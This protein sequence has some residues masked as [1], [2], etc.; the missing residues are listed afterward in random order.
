[1]KDNAFVVVSEEDEFLSRSAFF[2]KLAHACSEGDLRHSRLAPII[3]DVLTSEQRWEPAPLSKINWLITAIRLSD[4]FL[5]QIEAGVESQDWQRDF[6]MVAVPLIVGAART[7]RRSAD[8]QF[9]VARI[10]DIAA[11]QLRLKILW[12]RVSEEYNRLINE[13][14]RSGIQAK[15]L[16]SDDVLVMLKKLEV[17][18]PI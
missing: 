12:P 10:C 8:A 16:E 4:E 11:E 17:L 3:L 7:L 15:E 13:I 14:Y 2:A 6:A 5:A 18:G 1:M 9:L